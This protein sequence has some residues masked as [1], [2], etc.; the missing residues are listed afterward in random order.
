MLPC[1]LAVIIYSRVQI[2][3]LSL[4]AMQWLFF[5]PE[6]LHFSWNR[7]LRSVLEM[8]CLEGI[9]TAQEVLKL[10]LLDPGMF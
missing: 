10:F 5:S 3:C 9:L 2:R 8:Y 1:S 4:L 6:Y 7:T